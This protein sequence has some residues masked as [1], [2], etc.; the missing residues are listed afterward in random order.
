MPL[1]KN[2]TALREDE[3][4]LHVDLLEENKWG[5]PPESA[6]DPSSQLREELYALLTKARPRGSTAVGEGAGVKPAKASPGGGQPLLFR[7][8]ADLPGADHLGQRRNFALH[9]LHGIGADV[10]P[11]N[12][13]A[14]VAEH[15]GFPR[16]GHIGGASSPLFDPTSTR[17]C[18]RK[19]PQWFLAV[20]DL[21]DQVAPRPPAR[22]PNLL[23]AIREGRITGANRPDPRLRTPRTIDLEDDLDLDEQIAFGRGGDPSPDHISRPSRLS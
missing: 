13:K 6:P 18:P 9:H 23:R 1:Q 2:I 11:Y 16:I 17:A 22:Y 21:D 19:A 15:G 4:S 8:L 3:T 10:L 7:Y 20:L 14:I 12:T 5:R